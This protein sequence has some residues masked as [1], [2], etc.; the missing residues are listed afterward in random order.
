MGIAHQ[1]H[2]EKILELR[3]ELNDKNVFNFDSLAEIKEALIKYKTDTSFRV[4]LLTSG[5]KDFFSNGLDPKMFV[6]KSESETREFF[7]YLFEV[8]ELFYKFP[9][10][11][12]SVISGHCFGAAAVMAVLSDYRYMI[13]SNVRMCFPEINVGISFPAYV[14]LI[15]KDLVGMQ[16]ARDLLFTGKML[17]PDDAKEIGLVDEVY[18]SEELYNKA[19]KLAEKFLNTSYLSVTTIK[20]AMKEQYFPIIDSVIKNDLNNLIM[21][22]ASPGGQE[23]FNAIVENR[24]PKFK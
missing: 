24:R 17:K 22:S 9:L 15:L 10:P 23:G 16:N 11:I 8:I 7:T 12:I 13:Q 19:M 21:T 1:I 2:K 3:L 6:G 5:K 4:A 20:M 14:T 18:S